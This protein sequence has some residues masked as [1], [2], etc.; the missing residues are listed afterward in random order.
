[1]MFAISPL[2]AMIAI[3]FCSIIF[4]YASHNSAQVKWGDGFQGMK[5]QIARNILTQMDI[6]A[7]TK[8]WRPQLL[9]ITQATIAERDAG[10][11]DECIALKEPELLCLASQLKGGRGITIFGGVC[12]TEGKDIFADG[13]NFMNV[14]QRDKVLDGQHAMSRLLHKWHI[15]GFGR[16]VHTEDFSSG[17]MSLVQLSG[18]G[19]FQPNCVLACW[20]KEAEW[21]LKTSKGVECRSQ[22]IHMIQ[23]AVVF[24]K[25]MLLAKGAPFPPLNE[26]LNGNIDI[27]WIVADGGILLL[28]PFLLGKHPVWHRCHTRLFAVAD[29]QMDDPEEVKA[30]LQ[31]YVKDFRLNIEV[32]VKVIDPEFD[33][34]INAMEQKED[35]VQSKSTKTEGPDAPVRE[36][37]LPRAQ[38]STASQNSFGSGVAKWRHNASHDDTKATSSFPATPPTSIGRQ[39]AQPTGLDAVTFDTSKENA[40]DDHLPAYN[41]AKT[42][43]TDAINRVKSH[44]F[45]ARDALFMQSAEQLKSTAQCSGQEMTLARGLNKMIAQ[46][47]AGSELVVTN[48]PDMPPG[49][50]AYG[51]FELVE[52]MTKNVKRCFLVRGTT[53]E[54]ITAFT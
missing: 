23:V 50:S 39:A 30:H 6:T 1:M 46:E 16:V 3:V 27:W 2:F 17:I 22:L 44:A 35:V 28:L 18:L 48:L 38:V 49:E 4:T 37:E 54:V 20:P 10:E 43:K 13:G 52:E 15:E 33:E 47:S 14:Q 32:Y 40:S 25:V 42:A 41:S 51:Y 24:Q 21:R 53:T 11:Q 7:H 31:A 34:E 9:V 12:T 36:D 26:R 8:N 5:F 19:A 45:E 29:G